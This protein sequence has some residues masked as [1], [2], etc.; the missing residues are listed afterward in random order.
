MLIEMSNWALTSLVSFGFPILLFVSYIGSLG[1]PFPI[2]L[3]IVAAGAFTRQGL[4]D[5]RLALLAC[6]AGAALADHSEYLLGRLAQPWLV[7]RFG[8][9]A[10]WKQA[11]SSI[12]RQGGW[13]IL[14]T[15]FW[16]TPLAPAVNVISGS[17]YPY[18]RFLLFDLSGEL[19]WVLLYGGLGFIFA[20]QWR[21]VSQVVSEFSTLSFVLLVLA[22]GAYFL[23][24]RIKR[25]RCLAEA[26][27]RELDP[28]RPPYQHARMAS[29][30]L[31]VRSPRL[32]KK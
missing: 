7:R 15:R 16:L 4:M 1:I 13:A 30:S 26:R 3:V 25:N 29:A 11:D 22:A 27:Q 23:V 6:L 20:S 12:N 31:Y 9:K 17:R 18:L 10:A 8:K 5:W 28:H 14:L 21:L 32:Y 2:T 24:K 19:L